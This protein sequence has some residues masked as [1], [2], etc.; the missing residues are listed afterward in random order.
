M[1]RRRESPAARTTTTWFDAL[2]VAVAFLGRMPG[3]HLPAADLRR[4]SSAQ[5]GA[6]PRNDP[7]HAC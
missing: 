7:P 6:A 1:N 5:P 3:V 2:L 4:R